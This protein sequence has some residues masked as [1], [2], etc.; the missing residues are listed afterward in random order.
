MPKVASNSSNPPLLKGRCE[1][2]GTAGRVGISSKFYTCGRFEGRG[3]KALQVTT[4]IEVF[5]RGGLTRKCTAVKLF[6]YP[7]PPSQ[8]EAIFS[9]LQGGEGGLTIFIVCVLTYLS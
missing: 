6:R 2:I 5:H 1:K 4:I 8:L 9:Q 3:N 7:Y